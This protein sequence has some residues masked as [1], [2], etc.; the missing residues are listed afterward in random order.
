MSVRDEPPG[1]PQSLAFKLDAIERR[2]DELVSL[3]GDPEV[4]ASPSRYRDISRQHADLAETVSAWQA[5]KRTRQAIGDARA[6]LEEGDDE[7][8]AL[9]RAELDALVPEEA[10]LEGL[11]VVLL[12]PRDPDDG[13][14]VLLE[15]RAGTGG[16]EASLFAADLF[17]M[18]FRYADTVGWR[19]EVLSASPSEVGGFKEIVAQVTGERVFSRLKYEAGVHRVQRIPATEAQGRIHTST[20]TVAV[21]PEVDEVEVQ[22][23]PND[24]RIDVFRSSGSGGQSVNT[25]DS[26][27]RVTHL[28]TGI[29]ISCQDER[30]QLKNKGRA[31]K[32]LAARLRDLERERAAAA[33]SDARRAQV[34]TG[35]RSE[36]IRTYNFPQNRLTDHR[37]GLTTH[38]LDAVIAGA[39]LGPVL[40]ACAAW[41]NAEK[42][43]LAQEADA[44][45]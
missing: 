24:L 11:V 1:R 40:D 23:D 7:L 13:R 12:L 15:I 29:V 32:I 37:I 2:H 31:L 10:R 19:V 20:C 18:Y 33:E 8:R 38:D 4:A 16:D 44:T 35:M 9:A 41:F 22:V 42:L 5:L 27:V 17:R 30:S 25:A 26:A 39:S 6:L 43:R 14:D 3:M 28:P 21:M 34:G 36:R 45:G